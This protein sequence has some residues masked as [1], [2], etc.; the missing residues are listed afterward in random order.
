MPQWRERKDY[1]KVSDSEGDED[2]E[3]GGFGVLK[4][5]ASLPQK[6]RRKSNGGGPPL[7]HAMV[8]IAKPFLG[9]GSP[10]RRRGIWLIAGVL[11]SLVLES[12]ILLVYS[13]VQKNYMTALE[14]KSA[15][16]FYR[17]LWNV[18][19]IIMCVLP[20][21]GTHTY[22][23]QA[24]ELEWR[25]AITR[26][27]AQRYLSG[28][29][30]NGQ[31]MFYKLHM[32]GALDNPDQRICDD[33]EGLVSGGLQLVVD[34]IGSVM[35]LLSFVPVLYR[36]S[37]WTCF[38]TF[39]YCAASTGG[40]IFGFGIRIFKIQNAITKQQATLRYSLIRVR[41]NAESVAFFRG[42]PTEWTKFQLMF[43]TLADTIYRKVRQIT[44]FAMFKS[45][46]KF[47]AFAVPVMLVGPKYMRGEAEFGEI[48]QTSFAFNM[49]FEAL[50]LITARVPELSGMAV[51]ISRVYTLHE[52]L[53]GEASTLQGVSRANPIG[54]SSEP[55]SS[56]ALREHAAEDASTT[57]DV[58]AMTLMTPPRS[59]AAQQTIISDLAFELKSG[60]SLMIVGES[61]IGKS[62][63][64]RAIAGLWSDGFGSVSRCGGREVFFMPQR[65]YMCL[66][67]LREQL[68]Y[69]HDE[70]LGVSVEMT[71]EMMKGALLEVKLGY[72][73]ERHGL[74]TKQDWSGIL[75]LGEQQRINFARVLLQ[76]HL[77]LALLDE[78][79]SACDP[80]SEGRLYAALQKKVSS[81]V[82]VGH[83]PG[84]RRYHTHVLLLQRAAQ[85]NVVD[86]SAKYSYLSM[87]DFEKLGVLI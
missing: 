85:D 38:G 34:I 37:P 53:Q 67:T 54:L 39:V 43:S 44:E 47:S 76:P 46:V 79:T 14:G 30:P 58:R 50:M 9:K 32:N 78:G 56:I 1:S 29:G 22:L 65:P 10:S 51:R 72:L 63:L 31:G 36:I 28:S 25:A 75:S 57:L 41:E 74:D 18:V 59:G 23:Q 26:S 71:A 7:L 70:M 2:V 16:G 13:E 69:P 84:L 35:R 45:I 83:R 55:E 12:G 60:A 87:K 40:A 11:M 62:S 61:G 86:A 15:D 17:G 48:A 52:V 82:S 19:M 33:V 21:I 42:G 73:L 66:G 4:T 27:M 5:S 3:L 24:L 20:I 8:V 80:E 6:L 81:Y 77:Q 49:I 64:L 68:L